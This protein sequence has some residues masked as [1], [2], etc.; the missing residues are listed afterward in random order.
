MRC[1]CNNARENYWPRVARAGETLPRFPLPPS[2]CLVPNPLER[3]A[4]PTLCPHLSRPI[5]GSFLDWK[6]LGLCHADRG[7]I[8]RL[9]RNDRA[10]E[11]RRHGRRPETRREGEERRGLA[12]SSTTKKAASHFSPGGVARHVRNA[13]SIVASGAKN[14]NRESSYQGSATR[15]NAVW[16][17][18]A[19]HP[20]KGRMLKVM[21]AI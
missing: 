17:K 6:M 1:G 9:L 10:D 5:S 11:Q 12:V 20:P 3:R 21:A 8:A 19:R 4:P 16:H 18:M 7:W 13:D 14:A 2:V 15:E